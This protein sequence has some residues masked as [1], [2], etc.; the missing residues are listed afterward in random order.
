[1]SVSLKNQH[2]GRVGDLRQLPT[3]SAD[4]H[5]CMSFKCSKV[6]LNLAINTLVLVRIVEFDRGLPK[7]A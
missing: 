7:V 3:L 6:T 1:M 2:R 5:S 4:G